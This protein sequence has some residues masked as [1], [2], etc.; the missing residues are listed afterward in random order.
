M[1]WKE[2]EDNQMTNLKYHGAVIFCVDTF[3]LVAGQIVEVQ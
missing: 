2:D 1:L 3:L